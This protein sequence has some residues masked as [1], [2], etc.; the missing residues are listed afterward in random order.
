M[1]GG[2]RGAALG[3]PLCTSLCVVP[4]RRPSAWAREEVGLSEEQLKAVAGFTQ[5]WRDPDFKELCHG[6]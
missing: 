5:E 4:P 6:A 1:R 3:R 2:G